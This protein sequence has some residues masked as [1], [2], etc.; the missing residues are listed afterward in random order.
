M[1]SNGISGANASNGSDTQSQAKERYFV[2][3]MNNQGEWNGQKEQEAGTIN[4][5]KCLL[6]LIN[7]CFLVVQLRIHWYLMMI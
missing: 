5:I 3:K 7:K 2:A 6:M 1:K 4:L